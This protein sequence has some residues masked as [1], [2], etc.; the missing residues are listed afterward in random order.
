MS[1]LRRA[2]EATY[3]AARLRRMAAALRALPAA[4]RANGVSVP[5]AYR[6]AAALQRRHGF[7]VH[8]TVGFGLLAPDALDVPRQLSKRE[9]IRLQTRLNPEVLDAVTED[10]V[11]FDAVCRS[12]GLPVA[13]TVGVL[14]RGGAGW[15]DGT[16]GGLPADRWHEAL[17][18]LRGEFIIKP[19]NGCHGD[20]VRA[21]VATDSGIKDVV[22]GPT[23]ARTLAAELAALPAPSWMVQRRLRNHP[24]LD[25]LG[26]D[27]AVHTARIVT[28]IDGA[29]PRVLFAYW[30]IATR[31]VVDNF[32]DG[33]RGSMMAELDPAT[34][35]IRRVVH[36]DGA[37][38]RELP[39]H[40]NG[41]PW[42]AWSPPGWGEAVA[43][44]VRAANAVRPLRTVG[45]DVAFTPDG[46]VLIEGNM[47]WDNP[48]VTPARGL[49]PREL[50][51]P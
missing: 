44:A 40:P 15:M 48:I 39:A 11:V 20:D 1:V 30:R 6:R 37:R 4:A 22:A 35:A 7:T 13:P 10:K 45:W 51:S 21:I 24:A 43:L 9:A 14:H 12:A 50:Y 5:A 23:D 8:E 26:A 41:R 42:D 34:G 31:G 47:W 2:R 25:G 27:S 3:T 36:S 32:A 17:G 19:S 49:L 29:E 16:V 33:A 46:P 28:L 18:A 38:V